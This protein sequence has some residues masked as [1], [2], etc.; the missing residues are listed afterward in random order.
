MA[1]EKA[2]CS[3]PKTPIGAAKSTGPNAKN[4]SEPGELITPDLRMR[5]PPTRRRAVPTKYGQKVVQKLMP[6]PHSGDENGVPSPGRSSVDVHPFV[7][8]EVPIMGSLAPEST[9]R[10]SGKPPRRKMLAPG[11]DMKT[12]A[13]P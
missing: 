1:L 3:V 13:K 7:R 10:P 4:R 6:G 9:S 2:K 11:C 8:K 5:A 12:Q